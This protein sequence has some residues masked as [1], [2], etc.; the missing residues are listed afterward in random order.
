MAATVCL[1]VISNNPALHPVTDVA[2]AGDELAEF[3]VPHSIN[4]MMRF[5][6]TKMGDTTVEEADEEIL[7]EEDMLEAE[8]AELDEHVRMVSID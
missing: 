5:I 3:T 2:S 7:Q 8:E 1:P 6:D 4:D